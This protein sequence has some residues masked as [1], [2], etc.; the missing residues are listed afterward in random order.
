MV[1]YGVAGVNEV[2]NDD[3]DT[4]RY[5]TN[6]NHAC[7]LSVRNLGWSTFLVDKRE[8]QACNTNQ[9]LFIWLGC[10]QLATYRE[11]RRWLTRV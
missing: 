2:V 8:A 1:A 3:T 9:S 5:V 6:Q 4:V 11:H 10:L 7:A